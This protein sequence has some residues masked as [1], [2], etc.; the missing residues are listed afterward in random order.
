MSCQWLNIIGLFLDILGA[1]A[2]SYSLIINRKQA[3]KLGVPKYAGET[4]EENLKLP[5]VK[6]LLKQSRNA[7]IGLIL[8]IIGFIL[9]IIANW[10]KA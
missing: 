6:E 9:Q 5:F 8:L 10:P 4:D 7:K 1:I 3:I 2:L